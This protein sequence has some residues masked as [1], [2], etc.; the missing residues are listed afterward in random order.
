MR[1]QLLAAALLPLVL[2]AVGDAQTAGPS[3]PAALQE[4]EVLRD[5]DSN[6]VEITGSGH[7]A[8][9]FMTLDSPPRVVVLLPDTVMSTSYS[10]IDVN[11]RH[12]KAV[13]IGTDGRTPPTT[14]VVIDCLETCRY[15]LV[16]GSSNQVTLRM[17][18]ASA[19]NAPAAPRNEAPPAPK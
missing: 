1:K 17:Y 15:E 7:W 4:V 2:L 13:R 18:A 11:S 3:G 5:G 14:S 10:H 12:V 19:P 8:P 16:P 6:R 9:K